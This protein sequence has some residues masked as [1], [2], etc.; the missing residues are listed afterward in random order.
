[1]VFTPTID[2]VYTVAPFIPR[3]VKSVNGTPNGFVIV[4]L[5]VVVGVAFH[6]PTPSIL[7]P[8]GLVNEVIVV[9][10]PATIPTTNL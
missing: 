10:A 7:A 2:L 4:T 8:V 3:L 5:V 6:P 1:M 9:T